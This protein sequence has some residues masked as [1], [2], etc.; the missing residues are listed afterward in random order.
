MPNWSFSG[1]NL[2]FFL[3]HHWDDSLETF[4]N[5]PNEGAIF[6]PYDANALNDNL[7]SL[8]KSRFSSSSYGVHEVIYFCIEGQRQDDH[9]RFPSSLNYIFNS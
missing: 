5:H 1:R 8:Y 7:D 6:R 3:T 2:N 4:L 9:L